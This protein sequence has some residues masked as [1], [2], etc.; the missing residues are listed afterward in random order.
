MKYF[1]K[2]YYNRPELPIACGQW[3]E[4][5]AINYS[6]TN[7]YNI[8]WISK[9]EFDQIKENVKQYY[10]NNDKQ[11]RIVKLKEIIYVRQQ[12]NEDYTKEQNE[13]NELQK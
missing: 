3:E 6:N 7:D 8:E 11:E 13:L 5:D 9:K 10:I 2:I 12:I 1:K 4:G